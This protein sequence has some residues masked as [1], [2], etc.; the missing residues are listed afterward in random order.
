MQGSKK[1]LAGV[2]RPIA[3]LL[4]V[5]LTAAFAGPEG[6]AIKGWETEPGV[7]PPSYAV[8]VP[9]ASNLNVDTVVLVCDES[10]HRRFLNLELYLSTPG[11]LLPSG[12]DPNQLK[13]HPA[14]DIVVDGRVF[15]AALLFADDY[16]VVADSREGARPWL[17][18]DLLDAMQHGRSVVLRFDLL[19]EADERSA[20]FDAELVVDLKAGATAIAAV[21]RCA[22]PGAYQASR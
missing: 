13:E 10:D 6:E 14:V 11:P 4:L 1:F 5:M 12:A 17:S 9:I 15:P 7:N 22:S 8:T 2:G 19:R 18:N 16:V 20:A 3:A 21:R